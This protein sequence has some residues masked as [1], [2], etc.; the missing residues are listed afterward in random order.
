M[1]N[2]IE[3]SHK[4]MRRELFDMSRVERHAAEEAVRSNNSEKTSLMK[5]QP[6]V[7]G[8]KSTNV[9]LPLLDAFLISSVQ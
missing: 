1:K 5:P 2:S 8:R 3:L 9:G 7:R 4:R 6:R